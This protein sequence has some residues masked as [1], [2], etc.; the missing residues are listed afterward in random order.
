MPIN[1]NICNSGKKSEKENE[2]KFQGKPDKILPLKNSD[3]ENKVA[4]ASNSETLL[5][6]LKYEKIYVA[7][8]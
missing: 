1:D 5:N 6:F 8:P 4:K 2:I 7:K 3:T